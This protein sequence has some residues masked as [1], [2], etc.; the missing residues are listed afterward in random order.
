LADIHNDVDAFEKFWRAHHEE[1]PEAFPL[2]LDD[3]AEWEDEFLTWLST[4]S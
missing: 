3:S 2:I 1:T 4:K